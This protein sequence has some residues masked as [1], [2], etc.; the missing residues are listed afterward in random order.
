M[1]YLLKINRLNRL[2]KTLLLLLIIVI[3]HYL[4]KKFYL[5]EG[6]TPIANDQANDQA[7]CITVSDL[8]NKQNYFNTAINN[9]RMDFEKKISDLNAELEDISQK[10]STT[11]DKLSSVSNSINT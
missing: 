6:N 4:Y 2:N 11:N 1:K 3:A 5:I 10:C 8:A 9:F 7:K